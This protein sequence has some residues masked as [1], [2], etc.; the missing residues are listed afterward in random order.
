MEP[1]R[2]TSCV[3]AN[4]S[5]LEGAANSLRFLF[6]QPRVCLA[7]AYLLQKDARL[8]ARVKARHNEA[9]TRGVQHRQ[10]EALV[11]P[12][13]GKGVLADDADTLNGQFAMRLGD[14][15]PARDGIQL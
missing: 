4:E 10:H 3:T 11:G 5:A 1:G 9:I 12:R 2:A 14:F 6:G 15:Q 7:V 13:I 8:L